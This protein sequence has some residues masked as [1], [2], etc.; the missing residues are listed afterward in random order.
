MRIALATLF[1]LGAVGA[2]SAADPDRVDRE[3]T[4]VKPKAIAET[5]ADLYKRNAQDSRR[6]NGVRRLRGRTGPGLPPRRP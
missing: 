2:M 5:V 1:V 6:V 3:Y 4:L